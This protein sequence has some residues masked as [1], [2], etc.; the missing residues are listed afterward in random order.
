MRDEKDFLDELQASPEFGSGE[1]SKGSNLRTW[2]DVVNAPSRDGLTQRL[3]EGVEVMQQVEDLL[4]NAML[5]LYLNLR[6]CNNAEANNR[7]LEATSNTAYDIVGPVSEGDDPLFPQ[8]AAF[9][10]ADEDGSE[11][12]GES[13]VS[14]R[15]RRVQAILKKVAVQLHGHEGLLA[16][17]CRIR[18]D[19]Q[20]DQDGLEREIKR[21]LQ[22]ATDLRYEMEKAAERAGHKSSPFSSSA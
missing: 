20:L 10:F 8:S 2:Q 17:L 7:L 22:Q 21:L 18:L 14:A 16:T 9:R 11:G 1:D 15:E 12:E 6:S 4:Q 5:G 13:G 19:N 3:F